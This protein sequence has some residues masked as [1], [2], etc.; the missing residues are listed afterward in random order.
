MALIA[1]YLAIAGERE[2]GSLKLLLGLPPSRGEVLVGKF[3][4]RSGVVAIGLVLGFLVSG[5]V[6]VAIYGGLP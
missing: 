5:V 1:A 2:S 6:T 3:L 4:G